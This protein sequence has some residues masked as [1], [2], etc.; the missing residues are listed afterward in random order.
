MALT[1]LSGLI[2]NKQ[3]KMEDLGII[4]PNVKKNLVRVVNKLPGVKNLKAVTK[5]QISIVKRQ[6]RNK[7]INPLI[8]KKLL[9]KLNFLEN[10]LSKLNGEIPAELGRSKKRGSKPKRT[11]GQLI[12]KLKAT[13]KKAKERRKNDKHT[14]G[15]KAAH[16]LAKKALLVPRGAF[17][18][19][20]LLGKALE[21]TP[22]KIN[23]A[24]RIAEKWSTKGKQLSEL[25]YKL[26]GEPDILKAQVSKATNKQLAGNMGYVVAATTAGSVAAA[27][28]IIVKI[29]Q[30]VGKGADFAKKNPKLV[31]V[32]EKF[33]KSKIQEIAKKKGKSKELSEIAE[34]AEEL[35]ENLSPETKESV[36]DAKETVSNETVEKVDDKATEEVKETKENIQAEEN[37]EGVNGDNNT[38]IALIGAAVLVGGY[39]L[40]KKK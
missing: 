2:N 6:L 36:E 37:N 24:K 8:R 38:K 16:F 25:W 32:G 15:Q 21:K 23:I 10:Q 28:P 3:N 12:K 14:P 19:L 7:R 22:I 27:S 34:T 35:T 40:M 9:R 31:A 1:Y 20:I 39:L 33:L 13:V 29:L 30:I 4:Y 17:L 18:G 5:N 11:K 26:G